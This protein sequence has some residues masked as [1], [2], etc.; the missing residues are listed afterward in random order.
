MNNQNNTPKIP[1]GDLQIYPDY[2][3]LQA[4][5]GHH[6]QLRRKE[7][8]L[9]KFLTNNLNRVIN[10]YAI[11]DLVWDL[12]GFSGSNTLEVHLSN[13]RRK[14]SQLSQQVRIDT[15]RG[16]GYRLVYNPLQL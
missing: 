10:K 12:N 7:F 15:I 5:N 1:L 9:L 3:L 4:S 6:L 8:Q 14:L 13:L 11:M 2:Q 16:V